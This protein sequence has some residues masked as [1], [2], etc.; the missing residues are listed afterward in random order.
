MISF[1]MHSFIDVFCSDFANLFLETLKKK[2]QFNRTVNPQSPSVSRT[3][4]LSTTAGAHALAA[5]VEPERVEAVLP[6][7][8]AEILAAAERGKPTRAS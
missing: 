3:S 7:L 2:I 8:R 4:G 6:A 1:K 5:R